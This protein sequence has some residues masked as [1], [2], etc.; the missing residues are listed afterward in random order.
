RVDLLRQLKTTTA[1]TSRLTL[2]AAKQEKRY[3]QADESLQQFRRANPDVQ[4]PANPPPGF[5]QGPRIQ[6]NG[7]TALDQAGETRV[8][9]GRFDSAAPGNS[10]S[11]VVPPNGNNLRDAVADAK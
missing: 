1:E 11:V 6:L 10:K 4:A 2:E 8:N 7:R 5:R 9:P 3:Q